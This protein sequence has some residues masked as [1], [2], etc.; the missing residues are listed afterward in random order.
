MTASVSP[1]TGW[2]MWL[3]SLGMALCVWLSFVD[4]Q[5]LAVL[6]P[7]ILKET[8]MSAQ[9]F[10]NVVFF[11]FVA[12]TI[13]SPIWGSLLDFVGLRVGMLLAVGLWSLASAS[14]AWMGTVVGFAASRALLGLGEGAAFPGGL[15]TAVESLPSNLRARGIATAFSGGTIGA[16][17]TP[18][19]FV[20]FALRFGWRSAFLLTGFFGMMWL[21]L[22][23]LVARPPYL[24]ASE[25]A[26]GSKKK[27]SWP[28]PLER[29]FWTIVFSYSLT[30]MSAGPILTLV[31]I[32]LNRRMGVSQAALAG[33]LWMPPLAWGIG[34]FFWGWI[35]DRYADN[36]K[37]T[38]MFLLLTALSLPFGLTTLTS[39]LPLAMLLISSS[40]FIAGGFQMVA[41][42]AGSHV[43]SREQAAMMSG[44]A[45]GS[46]SLVN[47]IVSP[48]IGRLFDQQRWAEAFWLIALCPAIG[49][50]VWFV[51]S[52]GLNS[53]SA[54]AAR[55]V[56][57]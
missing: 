16:V 2:R 10:G 38:G 12:Y 53:S 6:A 11:F 27:L 24:P 36:P 26:A 25:H 4:R 20:P 18:L 33:I 14:H 57:A 19:I 34:Y 50:A 15:R 5:V 13:S 41:L 43:F 1:A 48:I 46:W 21:V 45:T 37:P 44:I 51:L 8:G 35:A 55:P 32:Y 23:A 30:A 52:R 54:T 7:T 31:P 17:V 28:N 22:W 3:P 42:K 47:A 9:D 39:S 56:T 40:T 49:I 29:R